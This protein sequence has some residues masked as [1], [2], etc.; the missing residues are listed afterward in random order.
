[1]DQCSPAVKWDGNTC[2]SEDALRKIATECNKK[3]DSKINTKNDKTKLYKEINIALSNQ[4]NN[5]ICWLDNLQLNKDNKL[6]R[7]HKPLHPKGKSEWL[8]T[9][10]IQRVLSQ[11]QDKYHD[12]LLFGP[13]P[14]DF[15]KIIGEIADLDLKDIYS[16]GIRRIGVVYNSDPHDKP[17]EHWFCTFL[18]LNTGSHEF[19]DSV[20][21]APMTEIIEYMG[22]VKKRCKNVLNIEIYDKINTIQHQQKNNECG[23]YA[24]N[25]IVERLKGNEF[26][27]VVKRVVRDNEMNKKREVYFRQRAGKRVSRRVRRVRKRNRVYKSRKTNTTRKRTRKKSQ[28]KKKRRIREH[29]S[30]KRQAIKLRRKS[31]KKI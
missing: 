23:M 14:I 17:G 11:Y 3:Y 15:Y 16:R 9:S 19:F 20:G 22:R 29:D 30:N 25:Y 4:C 7:F 6:Y 2:F 28:K 5:E 21:D 31:R 26:E 27:D 8:S 24:I 1:M 18:D 13:Y 10:D 12:F